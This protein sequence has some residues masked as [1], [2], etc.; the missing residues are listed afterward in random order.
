MKKHPYIGLP[1]GAYWKRAAAKSGNEFAPLVDFPFK[2]DRDTRVAT[3][4]S[5][6]A[7]HIAKWL[8]RSGYRYVVIE[9]GHEVLSQGVREKFQYG[10]FSARYGN[11]YTCRQLLQ[12]FDRAYGA[13]SPQETVWQLGESAFVDPFRPNVQPGGFATREELEIDRAQHLS[14]VREMFETLDVFVFTLGLTEAWKNKEDGA[15]YPLCPGVAGGAFD[16]D[17]YEFVNFSASECEEDLS[18]FLRRLKSVNA[19]AKVI[20]TVSPVPLVAT[21]SGNHV[22]QATTYSKSVLRVAAEA[23]SQSDDSVAYFPSYEIICSPIMR[24]TYFAD[25]LRSITEAGVE[26]V[27]SVFS[28][29]CLDG[30]QAAEVRAEAPVEKSVGHFREEMTSIAEVLCDEELL[31]E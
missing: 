24:G 23:V 14:S 3:A 19:S 22:V 2:I 6:F 5:C 9:P 31:A 8:K 12:L 30:E 18:A 28:H 25:D 17:K 26:H 16:S 21:A 20:L 29:W 7:Q 13:Y 4:G 10:T 1:E 27:M 11:I 15:V